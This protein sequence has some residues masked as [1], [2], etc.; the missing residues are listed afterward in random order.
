[1]QEQSLSHKI[2]IWLPGLFLVI[3]ILA[4]YVYLDS[5]IVWAA[6]IAKLSAAFF[7][8]MPAVYLLVRPDLTIAYVNALGLIATRSNRSPQAIFSQAKWLP[9]HTTWTS[10]RTADKITVLSISILALLLGGYLFIN[11]IA[12]VLLR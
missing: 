7:L 1:M 11:A 10:L 3:A 6:R 2:L 12:E 8:L 4:L 5:Q 9:E